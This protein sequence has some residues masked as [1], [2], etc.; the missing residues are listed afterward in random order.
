MEPWLGSGQSARLNPLVPARSVG[1]V[2]SCISG[3]GGGIDVRENS[4]LVRFAALDGVGSI[5]GE[6]NIHWNP[7]LTELAPF[8]TTRVDGRL[9]I[10][11][12][13]R[14]ETLT[15]FEHLEHAGEVYLEGNGITTLAGLEQ[16]TSTDMLALIQNG[17][18]TDVR[19]LAA[20]ESVDCCIYMESN[21]LSNC[22]GDW[23]CA[24]DPTA[25]C[26]L[27]SDWQTS[28]PP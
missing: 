22:E 27:T 20:L 1:R 23:L 6:V 11:G 25:A 12:N 7:V 15:A 4:A 2:F 24:R 17:K 8:R 19:A 5:D 16:L 14:L 18:L 3:D 21:W 10:I 9:R 26:H 28:C 13:W